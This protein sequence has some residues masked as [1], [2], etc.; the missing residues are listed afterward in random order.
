MQR[1][2]FF[3]LALATGA[4]CL[5]SAPALA[6][7]TKSP[8]KWNR[9][10]DMVIVGAGGGGLMAA[11]FA[12]R[13]GLNVLVVEKMGL[14]GGS[15]L[16]CG[17]EWSVADSDEQRAAGIKDSE[18]LFLKDMLEVGGYRNDP[19]LVKAMIKSGRVAY[20][21]VTK[22]LGLKPDRVS[23]VSG[24]SVPRAHHFTPSDLIEKLWEHDK[25]QGV[26]FLMNTSVER[27]TW[28]GDAERINGV[29][30]RTKDGKT[31][32]IEAEK[33]V[34]IAS[35]GFT[36]NPK[37][38]EKYNPL[39]MK[40]EP[41]GG[42]GNTGDGMLMAQ[43]YGADT[44]DTRYIKATFGY[45]PDAKKYSADTL[46]GY[47]DGAIIVNSDGKRI[48][49]E[50]LSYKL[51]ADAALAQKDLN[52]FQL[53]DEPLRV[54]MRDKSAKYKKL[55]S[56]MDNGGETD[57]CLRGDTLEEVAEKAGIPPEALKT[58]V[59]RYNRSVESGKDAEFG[60]T[61]LT[62]G[63]GKLVKIETRPFYLYR[64]RGRI[65][66]TYCGV[67][68]DPKAEVVDVFGE[69][70]RGLWACGEVCGGVHGAAY[71][72]GTAVCK[73]MAYGRIAALEI[74]GKKA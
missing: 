62:S 11:A 37:L 32:F 66:A 20:E 8:K 24:M 43:A 64:T 25:A 36:R 30:A 59:E 13:A 12:R 72:T 15:T 58:T 6:V 21:F 40:T 47:Y 42:M 74:A 51:L 67:R 39:M 3:G 55:L 2:N 38:L 14:V 68:I 28:D 61:S 27:L 23:A 1:R 65:I 33:G 31:I 57:Y 7:P 22:E 50:S 53:F 56:P 16:L 18:E 48:V 73:A 29:R 69:P 10:A 4:G 71:M 54:A 35:G 46:H 49:N 41:E 17:G 52:N 5:A 63:F 44:L 26:E 60:R 34:L 19:E 45:R 70:I 9:S